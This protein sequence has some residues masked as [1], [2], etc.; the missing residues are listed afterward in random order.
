MNEQQEL[1]TRLGAELFE[2]EKLKN[3]DPTKL[4]EAIARFTGALPHIG[5]ALAIPCHHEIRPETLN[6]AMHLA[7]EA[8]LRGFTNKMTNQASNREKLVEDSI[9]AGY[10]RLVLMDADVALDMRGVTRLQETMAR[11][12][13][14]L[15][16]ALVPARDGSGL[17]A[18]LDP[19]D[20]SNQLVRVNKENIPRSGI[21]FDAYV[22]GLSVCILDLAQIKR[23]PV[24]RFLS[25]TEGQ[26]HWGDEE[27]FCKL[28]RKHHL[29]LIVDPQVNVIRMA[30]SGYAYRWESENAD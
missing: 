20:D 23:I 9:A 25:R 18:W 30:I 16:S 11:E 8:G 12:E 27:L 17:N 19:G 3:I 29:K 5:T 1:W 22:C 24:P 21:P 26:A 14:A 7:S 2:N 4:A 15:V 10:D 6:A 13:A 28:L